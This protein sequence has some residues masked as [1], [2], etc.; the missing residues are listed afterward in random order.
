MQLFLAFDSSLSLISMYPI[1]ALYLESEI[2]VRLRSIFP[3]QIKRNWWCLNVEGSVL[4]QRGT[5]FNLESEAERGRGK[6]VISEGRREDHI[7]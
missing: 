2:E 4:A 1:F 7:F 5:P 6:R 3:F